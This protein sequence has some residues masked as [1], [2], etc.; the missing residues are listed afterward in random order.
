MTEQSKQLLRDAHLSER[1]GRS[2]RTINRW[3]HEKILPAP[4]VTI[5]D[6]DYWYLETIEQNERERLSAKRQQ[7]DEAAA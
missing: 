1:Y 2:P 6:R 5:N 7:G 4:D 3:K